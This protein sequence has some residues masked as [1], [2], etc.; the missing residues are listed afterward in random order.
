MSYSSRTHRE[1]VN[2]SGNVPE[3]E[4]WKPSLFISIVWTILATVMTVAGFFLFAV[5]Y[6]LVGRS[7][8]VTSSFMETSADGDEV[9]V[10]LRLGGMLALIGVSVAVL[11]IHEAVHGAAF[12]FYGA[13]PTFGAA[14]VQKVLPV[15][16]ASAPGYTFSRGQFAVIILAP[17]VVISIAGVALMP[18]VRDG[19]LLV[20][21]LA[22]NFGGAVGDLWFIGLLL[23]RQPGTRIEDLKDGMRFHTPALSAV[24]R[25]P[26]PH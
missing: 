21:P 23:R 9:V 6:I 4:E 26:T 15:L 17:L 16:Y 19:I 11:V 22:V 20:V 10:T 18:L 14:L 1:P 24:Q 3:V 8:R 5:V 25:H 12:R 2:V 7:G 13:R